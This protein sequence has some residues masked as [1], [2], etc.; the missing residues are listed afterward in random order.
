MTRVGLGQDGQQGAEL[1]LDALHGAGYTPNERWD[2]ARG[3]ALYWTVGAPGLDEGPW[4]HGLVVFW[5]M[6]DG[7]HCAP[8]NPN[9]DPDRNAARPLS[10]DPVASPAALA[11]LLPRL[12]RGPIH[13]LR[14]T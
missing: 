10:L 9:G 7:W 13:S 1:D 5:R 11:D 8:F 12:L 4:T 3:T 6:A 2:E 14:Q